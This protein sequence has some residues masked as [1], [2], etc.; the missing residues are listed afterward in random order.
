MNHDAQLQCWGETYFLLSDF[1]FLLCCLELARQ[2]ADILAML[3]GEQ[4]KNI[5]NHVLHH[6]DKSESVESTDHFH[7]I[8]SPW[9]LEGIHHES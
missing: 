1:L 6:Y 2:L 4:G 7:S 3:E 8:T 5:T 9:L